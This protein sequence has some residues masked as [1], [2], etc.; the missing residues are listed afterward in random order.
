MHETLKNKEKYCY[1]TYIV[2]TPGFLCLAL[3][4]L[5]TVRYQV[6]LTLEGDPWKE[7]KARSKQ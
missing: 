4:Y 1:K 6:F 5:L 3:L 7:E 2:K